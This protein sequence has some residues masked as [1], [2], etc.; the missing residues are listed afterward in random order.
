[1]GNE[2]GQHLLELSCHQP[3]NPNYHRKTVSPLHYHK[4]YLLSNFTK[5]Y[6]NHKS[7]TPSDVQCDAIV[8]LT[9]TSSPFLIYIFM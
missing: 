6:L 1:M 2:D 4:V 3:A 5:N 8:L 7:L 9:Y